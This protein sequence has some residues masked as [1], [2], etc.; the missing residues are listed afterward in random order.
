MANATNLIRMLS[1]NSASLFKGPLHL[2]T[3]DR[4]ASSSPIKLNETLGIVDQDDVV[5]FEHRQQH[6][7]QLALPQLPFV[8]LRF[9][10]LARRRVR[11]PAHE[12]E[13]IRIVEREKRTEDLHA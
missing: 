3:E 6:V 2:I 8:E 10:R 5:L 4:S 9:H 13:G 12:K 7:L 1:P 11:K